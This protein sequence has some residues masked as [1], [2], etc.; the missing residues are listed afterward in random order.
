MYHRLLFRDFDS[1]GLRKV[2]DRAD[3]EHI[4][5]SKMPCNAEVEQIRTL[6]FSI[7]SGNY[8]FPVVVRGQFSPGDLCIGMAWGERVPTWLNGI[9]VGREHLQVYAEK[10]DI[11]YRAA[12]DAKW[13][14]FTVARECLQSEAVQRLGRELSLPASGTKHL[15]VNQEV[16]AHLIGIM[17]R[18]IPGKGVILGEPGPL[19]KMMIGAY[20]EALA[21]ADTSAAATIRQRAAYRLEIVRRGD[22]MM[23]CMIGRT[24]SSNQLCKRIGVSERTLELH[25]QD[26]LGVSPK[27]W[28][29]HLALH[30]A[31]LELLR[32]TPKKGLVTQVALACG[33][34][35]FGRFSQCY[36][37]L[38]GES[39]SETAAH[40]MAPSTSSQA[41]RS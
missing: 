41:S 29:H 39:P 6:D 40:A 25:F 5:I 18:M 14:G 1:E 13:I 33:F 23:R 8:G 26:A 11:L 16:T 24:Y 12:S 22:A 28:F 17:R 9:Q 35:H 15:L 21:S 7:D 32:Q 3:L 27:S 19:G 10:S 30:R 2:I 34:E 37:D 20:V 36:L 31:R 38:F 4:I